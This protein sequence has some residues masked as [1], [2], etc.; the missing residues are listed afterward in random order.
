MSLLETLSPTY[1]HKRPRCYLLRRDSQFYVG[2]NLFTIVSWCL[3]FFVLVL[4]FDIT[5]LCLSKVFDTV[6]LT[7]VTTAEKEC[8]PLF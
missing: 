2:C 4:G 8:Y 6:A 7:V 5:K 3:R 1:G